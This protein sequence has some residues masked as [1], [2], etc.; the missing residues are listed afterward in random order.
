M[1]TET[2]T[3]PH[4]AQPEQREVE[5]KAEQH[6]YEPHRVGLPPLVPYVRELW[7]RREFAFELSRTKLRAQHFETAFGQLW[8]V[9]NPLLLAG[10][11][12]V[13]I[14]I[15]RQ[16]QRPEGAFAHLVAGIFAYYFISGAIRDGTKS[17]TGGGRLILNSAFPRMLLPLASVV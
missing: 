11:Y 13:L 15:V 16:G 4:D 7:R 17:V 1:T 5:W 12:F 8:L 2:T 6:V 14:D 10:V 3:A 9:L